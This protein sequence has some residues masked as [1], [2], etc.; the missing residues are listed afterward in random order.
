MMMKTR[1]VLNQNGVDEIN[2]KKER[3]TRE[4]ESEEE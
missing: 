4:R 3:T 2:I 1:V